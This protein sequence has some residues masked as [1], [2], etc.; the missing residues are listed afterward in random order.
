MTIHHAATTQHSLL[1]I[2]LENTIIEVKSQC[3]HASAVLLR[4]DQFCGDRE[5]EGPAEV[6]IVEFAKEMWQNRACI[7][8]WSSLYCPADFPL[9]GPSVR[10]R[11]V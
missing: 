6:R 2:L 11:S 10:R 3:C 5:D 4:R 8:L 1:S 9:C 7:Q